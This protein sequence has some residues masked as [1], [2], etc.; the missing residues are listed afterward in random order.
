MV[1]HMEMGWR[2]RSS[3]NVLPLSIWSVVEAGMDR[4]IILDIMAS[5]YNTWNDRRTQ[6]CSW[7]GTFNVEDVLVRLKAELYMVR[8]GEK[9]QI[10]QR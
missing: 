4:A 3:F 7:D 9:K 10:I 1:G 8:V 2:S 6:G 5:A